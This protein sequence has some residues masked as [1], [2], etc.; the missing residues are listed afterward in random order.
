MGFYSSGLDKN[1]K[2][3]AA[4][5][6]N[7]L[8]RQASVLNMIASENL[9][10]GAVLQAS[11][12]VLTNKYAEG[13]PGRRYYAGCAFADEVEALAIDRA[14]ALFGCSFANVQPHSGSQM[15]QAV[16]LALLKPGDVIMGMS[17]KCGGHLTHGSA[18]NL[19][20]IWFRAVAYGV[21][22]ITG[23]VDMNS[24]LDLAIRHKPKLIIAGST[25]YPR[26]L[27]WGL[28]KQV[29][30]LVGAYL[31]ADI[32]HVAGLV[33]AGLYASPLR[34]C[35]VVTFTTH[36]S[37]RGPRGGVIV[38]NDDAVARKLSSAVFPGLQGG[39]MMH[40]IAAKAVALLEASAPSFKVWAQCVVANARA[41][42]S[43]F[44]SRGFKLVTGGTDTHVV[45]LDLR[46]RG[47]TGADAE[48]KLERCLVASNRNVLPFDAL[49]SVVASGL[50]LGTCSLT[51]RGMGEL[52]MVD[53][54]DVIS[55]VLCSS[56][57]DRLEGHVITRAKRRV[58]Q[59]ADAFPVL[60]K[61][62]YV[63]C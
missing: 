22:P 14:K 52:E 34:F 35:H 37:L 50:R 3:V 53:V 33:A 41:L 46:G 23:L 28:F 1:D 8:I 42:S 15:N 25:S 40:T 59:L 10:S 58:L 57:R 47:L 17:L 63:S 24:V 61:S 5:L 18:V 30:D 13:Y 60:Y 36:K 48:A 45:L 49:P 19:S 55:D 27:N 31:M 43:A 11:A 7:E 21:D 4:C 6:K 51:T 44:G 62:V 16:L 39:P 2:L 56:P 29:S 32:S 20:G 12:S 38:T 26:A 9:V 54:C